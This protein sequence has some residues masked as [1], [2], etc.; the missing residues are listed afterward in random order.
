MDGLLIKF[1]DSSM[2]FTE[3]NLKLYCYSVHK[4]VHNLFQSVIVTVERSI[5]VIP[6]LKAGAL[7]SRG[8]GTLCSEGFHGEINVLDTNNSGCV[9]PLDIPKII[10]AA[11]ELHAS[12]MNKNR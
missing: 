11:M 3:S 12:R 2:T 1:S 6:F 9:N 10:K 5:Q 8:I 7:N 4:Y